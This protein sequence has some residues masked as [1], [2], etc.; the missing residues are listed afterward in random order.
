MALGAGYCL[1]PALAAIV[2]RWFGY[3]GTNMFF[4][5]TMLVFGLGGFLAL[6]ERINSSQE[7][8]SRSK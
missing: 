5:V 1:G 6:P 7:S 8:K 2:I 3:L 4:A